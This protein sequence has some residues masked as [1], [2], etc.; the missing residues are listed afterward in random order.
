MCKI[1][2]NRAIHLGLFFSKLGTFETLQQNCASHSYGISINSQNRTFFYHDKTI[3]CYTF[4]RKHR[5]K[6]K[7]NGNTTFS[8]YTNATH[9]TFYEIA[10]NNKSCHQNYLL[11]EKVTHLQKN[12]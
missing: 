5:N 8:L 1:R 4:T 3:Y 10:N 6:K 9:L 12:L 2:S 7:S 11:Q